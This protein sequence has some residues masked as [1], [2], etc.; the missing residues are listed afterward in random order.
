MYKYLLLQY[1]KII[2]LFTLV[3]TLQEAASTSKFSDGKR[4]LSKVIPLGDS[5][6]TL[7]NIL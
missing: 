2:K 7:L 1:F 4:C 6:Y 3:T 5:F